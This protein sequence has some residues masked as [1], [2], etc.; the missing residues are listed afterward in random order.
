MKKLITLG[1][2]VDLLEIA[3]N[4]NGGVFVMQEVNELIEYKRFLDQHNDK[5]EQM[6]QH[7]NIKIS[8]LVESIYKK[9]NRPDFYT[10]QTKV[11]LRIRVITICHFLID[12]FGDGIIFDGEIENK[13]IKISEKFVWRFPLDLQHMNNR[14]QNFETTDEY[15]KLTEE[16][17]VIALDLNDK[18]KTDGTTRNS[19]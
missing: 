12:I 1:E 15:F 8:Q 6:E 17:K 5:R 19:K 3:Y 18:N 14:F 11:K 16:E 13:I 4:L 9:Q 7:T 10:H 2:K